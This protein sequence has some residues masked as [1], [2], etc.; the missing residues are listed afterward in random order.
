ML[1]HQVWNIRLIVYICFQCHLLSCLSIPHFNSHI[2]FASFYPLPRFGI[3]QKE[4]LARLQHSEQPH[5]LSLSATP[6]PRTIAL[7]K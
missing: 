5:V 2:T 4:S 1:A 3:R 7:V 6:I